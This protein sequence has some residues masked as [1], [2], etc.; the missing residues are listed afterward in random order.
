[1]Q[2]WALTEV[3]PATLLV[4]MLGAAAFIG[5]VLLKRLSQAG[6]DSGEAATSRRDPASLVGVLV[7]MLGIALASGPTRFAGHGL[8]DGLE[9]PRTLIT[10]LTIGSAVGLFYWASRTMGANWSIVARTL[11]DHR[12][13]T[14]GPFALVRHPI[15]LGMLLFLLSLAAATG[16]ERALVL[17][18]PIFALGT[19]V[20]IRSEEAL[21][22]AEF[23]AD[24]E[25]YAVRVKQFIPWVI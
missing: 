9:A 20:R 2:I 22:R 4:F 11:Q 10:A 24:Y 12:L 14:S 7:Q 8:L 21:L 17:A 25:A 1:M 15:Y 13:V 19:Q 3:K 18:V 6:R 23:G 16:H 5:A